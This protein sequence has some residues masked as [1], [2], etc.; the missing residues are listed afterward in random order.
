M[1]HNSAE[2]V[3][4]AVNERKSEM[5]QPAPIAHGH[6]LVKDLF[7]QFSS[8]NRQLSW[9]ILPWLKQYIILKGHN[10]RL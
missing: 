6:L 2:S 1:Q 4:N 8:H 9:K 5:Y 10:N 3:S 7:L